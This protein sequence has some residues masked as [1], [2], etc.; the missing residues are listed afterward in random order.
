MGFF[1][2]VKKGARWLGG[3]IEDKVEDIFFDNI[4]FGRNKVSE[5]VLYHLSGKSQH[6]KM[7]KALDD[8]S[9]K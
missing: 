2:E 5:G 7:K 8:L 6:D 9:K 1:N 4:P 3:K